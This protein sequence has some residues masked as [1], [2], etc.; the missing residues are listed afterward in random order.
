MGWKPGKTL[1]NLL[2]TGAFIAAASFLPGCEK[3]EP[4]EPPVKKSIEQSVA[5]NNDIEINY[6]ATLSNVDKAQ[7]NVKKEGVSI[8]TE[9]ISDVSSVGADYQKTYTYSV[10]T[11][12]TKGNYEFVLTSG[13]LQKT[14]SLQIQNYK[15]TGNFTSLNLSLNKNSEIDVTLPIPSDK[16]PEDNPVGFAN[17]KS[18]DGKTSL[19]LNG[20]NLKVKAL[21]NYIGGYQIELEY[22][23]TGGGLEKSVLQGNITGSNKIIVKYL[24][25]PND[26]TLNWYGSGDVNK[27]NTLESG[28]LTRFDQVVAGTFSDP[29][30]TRLYDRMDVNGDEKVNS[31][32]RKILQD[33]LNG[34]IVYLPGE[35]NKLPSIGEKLDWLTKMFAIDLTSEINP[36]PGWD[37]EEYSNQTMINFHGLSLTDISKLLEAHPYLDTTNNGRFNIPVYRTDLHV[38][39]S[40]DKRL[41]GHGMNAVFLENISLGWGSKCDIEPQFD[42]LNVQIGQD[43]LDG[44]NTEFYIRGPPIIKVEGPD[45]RKYASPVFY[46]IYK[47]KNNI[48][49]LESVNPD[50]ELVDN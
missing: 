8:S 9:Q 35:W 16:N 32:D 18:L 48:P 28:D 7:L 12:I 40:N 47:I 43:Y 37:C 44:T 14:N 38:Y 2:Y 19:T 20:N 46:I 25:Q 1:K 24:M 13:D 29:T 5:L 23:S 15:P 39:D 26:S 4:P 22:G 17:A 41:W 33:R 34:V 31:E 42:H 3:P 30:D 11:N 27:N 6:S 36:F 50:I 45:G 49:T 21:S 10:N